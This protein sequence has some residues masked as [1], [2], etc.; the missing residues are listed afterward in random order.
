MSSRPNG[1][2]SVDRVREERERDGS[3]GRPP[4][5]REWLAYCY[6]L[7]D[8]CLRC[9]AYNVTLTRDHVEPLVHGGRND[10]SNLQPL[11]ESCNSDKA[12]AATDYRPDGWS[13]L[14]VYRD[15]SYHLRSRSRSIP[16]RGVRWDASVLP[17]PPP[18]VECKPAPQPEIPEIPYH[19]SP[20]SRAPQRFREAWDK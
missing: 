16:Y 6:R 10:L 3:R 7:G 18:V 11:C 2:R 9:G 20:E 17:A 13:S 5:K 14:L 15:G 8:C 4:S 19:L 12:D 1:R